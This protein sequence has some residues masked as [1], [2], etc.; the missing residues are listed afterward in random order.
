[1]STLPLP[2]KPVSL[3]QAGFRKVYESFRTNR[4]A[5]TM[6]ADE[7]EADPR[8]TLERVFRLTKQQKERYEKASAKQL[9]ERAK[10]LLEELRSET[11]RPLRLHDEEL[12]EPTDCPGDDPGGDPGEDHIFGG[13]CCGLALDEQ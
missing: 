12:G 9:L 10:V 2:L 11:P 4:A 5:A 7:I 3:S 1:M 6:L 8:G 13:T